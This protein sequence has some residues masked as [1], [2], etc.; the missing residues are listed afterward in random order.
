MNGKVGFRWRAISSLMLAARVNLV[1]SSEASLAVQVQTGAVF[2]K[3]QKLA[4][5]L[6]QVKEGFAEDLQA[7]F[8]ELIVG[9]LGKTIKLSSGAT[10]KIASARLYA[11]DDTSC[12]VPQS[13][14]FKVGSDA[15]V[16]VHGT[17]MKMFADVLKVTTPSTCLPVD[18]KFAYRENA[19]GPIAAGGPNIMWSCAGKTELQ[20]TEKM[21]ASK[22]VE[23]CPFTE[24]PGEMLK[25]CVTKFPGCQLEC[26]KV[27]PDRCSGCTCGSLDCSQWVCNACLPECSC[28][29]K[30]KCCPRGEANST[31]LTV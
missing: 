8:V 15:C 16:L 13:H 21:V 6:D 23:T 9:K 1:W 19:C 14:T 25:T 7:S 20:R 30:D 27:C 18:V 10:C 29:G 2:T 26:E 31:W 11:A 22:V 12:Q 17:G 3:P 28:Y 4:A 5:V 24:C